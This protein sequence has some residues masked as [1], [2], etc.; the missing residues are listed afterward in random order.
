MAPAVFPMAKLGV[1]AFSSNENDFFSHSMIQVSVF[2][3]FFCIKDHCCWCWFFQILGLQSGVFA[4]IKAAKGWKWYMRFTKEN[5]HCCSHHLLILCILFVPG[6]RVFQRGA[7]SWCSGRKLERPTIS[8]CRSNPFK[9]QLL[10]L[11]GCFFGGGDVCSPFD[12]I[13]V[14]WSDEVMWWWSKS[15]SIFSNQI[16]WHN[17]FDRLYFAECEGTF[18]CGPAAT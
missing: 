12:A 7:T 5:S 1:A 10:K 6:Q 13:Y 14:R 2:H 17:T 9:R 18:P 8:R 15:F 11:D 16:C 3:T 4:S